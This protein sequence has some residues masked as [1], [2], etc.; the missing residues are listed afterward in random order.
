MS[1]PLTLLAALLVA[2]TLAGCATTEDFPSLAPRAIEAAGDSSSPAP[3]PTGAGADPEL[4][5]RL[6]SIVEAGEAGNRAFL[7]E[8]VTARPT[9]ERAAGAAAGSESWVAAQQAYSGLDSTRGALLSALADLDALRREQ[10]D[11]PNPGNHAALDQGAE[12]LTALES[13]EAS[14]LAELAAKLG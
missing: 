13:E 7:A 12:R 5:K 11:S 4:V 1:Q 9:I 2:A 10:V 3:P 14:T 8:L 6:S